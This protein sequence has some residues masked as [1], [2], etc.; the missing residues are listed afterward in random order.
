MPN[1]TRNPGTGAGTLR[2]AARL[3]A[4]RARWRDTPEGSLA[5]RAI[6]RWA[7]RLSAK[8]LPDPRFTIQ[9]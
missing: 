9:R 3:R 4:H 1:I 2:A 7:K 5:P 6:R 8:R